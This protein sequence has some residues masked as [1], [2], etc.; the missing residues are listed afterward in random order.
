MLK[1]RKNLLL[2]VLCTVSSGGHST[3]HLTCYESTFAEGRYIDPSVKVQISQLKTA[4][5]QVQ[6][7]HSESC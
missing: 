5:L 3:F 7:Q 6:F 4:S 2:C 1:V